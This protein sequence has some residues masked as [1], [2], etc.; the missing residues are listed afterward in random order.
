M[1]LPHHDTSPA[2]VEVRRNGARES[3]HLV[4]IAVVDPDGQVILG[5]GDVESHVF[6]RSAMKPLQSIALVE[7]LANS[8][9]GPE[10]TADELA[11]IC[12]SHNAEDMHVTA[13][14]DLLGKFGLDARLLTCGAHWSIDPATSIAQAKSMEFP[15]KAHNNCSGKHAGMV[16]LAQLMGTSAD[17]Y[18]ALNHPVQQRI[19]G[20][21]EQ[22][23]GLDLMQFPHGIDGC[24]APALSGPLGNWARGFAVFADPAGVSD[25]RARAIAALRQGIAASPKMI[26]GTGRACS[27]VAEVYGDA[28]TVKVGAEGVYAAAFHNL[29]LGMMLKTRDGNRRGAEAA[30]GAV[31]AALGFPPDDRLT[32]FFAPVLRN[33]AGDEVGTITVC[34]N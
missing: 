9:A 7:A 4:D 6:P 28:M 15:T 11:L 8:A 27:M 31:I 32:P 24:G 23:T 2:R 14:H 29:G 12:A 34:L 20:V 21:L 26:A 3:V 17:G 1:Q 22:M 25:E 19:L 10:L 5:C 33:W 18:A 30:L 13:V 16:V